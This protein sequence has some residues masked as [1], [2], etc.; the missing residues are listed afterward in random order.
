M[1]V[2]MIEIRVKSAKGGKGLAYGMLCSCFGAVIIVY[3]G[4]EGWIGVGIGIIFFT[5]NFPGR[6]YQTI[7]MDETGIGLGKKLW[8]WD[9]VDAIKLSSDF[10][11][12]LSKEKKSVILRSWDGRND[13]ITRI[14]EMCSAK[15]VPCE[16]PEKSTGE[17]VSLRGKLYTSLAVYTVCFFGLAYA[18]LYLEIVKTFYVRIPVSDRFKESQAIPTCLEE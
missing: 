16:I 13:Q 17:S 6:K 9:I 12:V 7:V 2:H 4:W 18:I 11:S 15:N 1:P 14:M 10:V 8:P 3:N 5:A